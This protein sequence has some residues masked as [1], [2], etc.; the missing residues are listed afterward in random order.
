MI[1][2]LDVQMLA[3]LMGV[4]LYLGAYALLQ[5]RYISGTGYTYPFLNGAAA[6]CVMISLIRDF[7]IASLLIQISFIAISIYGITRLFHIR[8]H[9]N[10]DDREADFVKDKLPNSS[11]DV[12]R[13]FLQSGEWLSVPEGARLSTAGEPVSHLYY[14]S[15]GL[16]SVEVCG[17]KIGTCKAGDFVGEITC[18][19]G[20]RATG[21]VMTKEDVE[22]FRI[23]VDKLKTLCNKHPILRLEI[24]QSVAENLRKKVARSNGYPLS[25][26]KTNIAS[27]NKRTAAA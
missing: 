23:A 20:E 13:K 18:F 27:D 5:F 11:N 16:C 25:S 8:N 2:L 17:K 7:N 15:S 10:F 3:G 21:T 6:L 9:I 22:L 1:N 14:I 24:E 19:N 12:A 26:A 4:A